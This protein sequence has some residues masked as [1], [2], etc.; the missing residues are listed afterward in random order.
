MCA[1]SEQR[2]SVAIEG[3]ESIT[4][5]KLLKDGSIGWICSHRSRH[6]EYY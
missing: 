1:V 5:S 6:R 2:Y 3:K 4:T